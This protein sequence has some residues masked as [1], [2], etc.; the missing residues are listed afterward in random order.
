M[1]AVRLAAAEEVEVVDK[2]GRSLVGNGAGYR[3]STEDTGSR[4]G[5]LEQARVGEGRSSARCPAVVREG[6]MARRVALECR[7]P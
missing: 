3:M 1:V 7:T 4:S 5:C 6:H 2:I